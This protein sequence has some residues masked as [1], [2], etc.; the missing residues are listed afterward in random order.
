[1][2]NHLIDKLE[3][4]SVLSFDEY[5]TLIRHRNECR[6]YLRD[7]AAQMRDKVYSNRVFIR[8][9]IEFSNYCK[10]NC[11]YCGIRRDNRNIERFRL[12]PDEIVS[13]ADNGYALGFRTFV[14]QGGEDAHFSDAV[15]CDIISR[16]KNHHPDC[17]VTLSLGERTFESYKALRGAGADRYLLRH[18]T[19]NEAHY[20]RLHP[21]EMSFQNR[22]RCINDLKS[23]GY[24]VGV[25]FMV[26]SP[27]QTD[28]D[29]AREMLFLKK[30]DPQ[31]VGIGPFIRHKDT[32]FKNCENGTAE[33]TTFMLSLIRLTLPKVLLPATTALG[34]IDPYGR[35]D[36]IRAGANVLMP[37]LSPAYAKDKY[38]LYNGKIC[39]GDEAAQCIEC[40]KQ[41]IVKTGCHIVTDRGDYMN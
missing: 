17:A 32:P 29:L 14:L 25:G 22:L 31:M 39:T 24:Q 10:N 27:Y 8:G 16:I 23:L 5:L 20:K 38:M 15:F 37:N 33:M 26:G 36:G 19:A 40:L 21:D 41:R 28:E 13:C 2:Y 4:E 1:M 34:T 18:E 35:E 7:K 9:L 11:Y 30:I 6:D 3:S 12:S